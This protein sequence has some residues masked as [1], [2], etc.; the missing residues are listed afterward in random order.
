MHLNSDFE[1]QSFQLLLRK[2]FRD[3]LCLKTQSSEESSS[4]GLSLRQTVFINA[5][6]SERIFQQ[7]VCTCFSTICCSLSAGVKCIIAIEH[8]YFASKFTTYSL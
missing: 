1:L 2:S 3:H 7:Q 5:P 6:E 4:S 8:S